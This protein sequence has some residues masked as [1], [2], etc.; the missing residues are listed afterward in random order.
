MHLSW[1]FVLIS[2]IILYGFYAYKMYK[3]DQ[4]IE[5]WRSES[6]KWHRRYKEKGEE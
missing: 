6:E 1:V 2:L 4:E 5:R 3:K